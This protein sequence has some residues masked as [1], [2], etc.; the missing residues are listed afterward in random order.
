MMNKYSLQRLLP[1]LMALGLST[2]AMAQVTLQNSSYTQDFDGIGTAL[3]VGFSVR[4]G[5]TAT[6]LGTEVALTTAKTPWA[7]TSGRFSNYASADGLTA[8]ADAA[9]QDASTDRALG[10]RQTGSFGDPGAAFVFQAVNTTNKTSFSLSFKLQS[11]DNTSARTTAWR[12]DYG[13]GENPTNFQTIGSGTSLGNTSFSNTPITVD[14]ENALNNKSE[15]VWIRIVALANS[16]GSGSRPTTAIDDFSLTWN[17]VSATDPAISVPTTPLTFASQLINTASASQNY[18]ISAVNLTGDVTVT[19]PASFTVSK[20]NTAFSSTITFTPAELAT[21]KPVYVRY[22]PTAIG[23]AS[24]NIT[25]TTP[26]GV[27]QTVAVSGTAFDPNNLLFSFDNCTGSPSEGWTQFSVTGAQTWGCTTFGRDANDA[28]GKASKPNGLQINGF[29]G[30]SVLN[31][32]WLISPALNTSSFAYPLLSFYSRVAFSGAPL[33]LK[34][35]TNYSGTGSPNAAGVTWT[36]V[37]AAFPAIGSDTWTLTDNVDL[38]AF[39]SA[40]L[41]VAFVYNS[42]TDE[43]ARWTLDDIRVR[44]STTA[45]P[46]S[47]AVN[48]ST[49]AFGYRAPN[50]VTTQTLNVT[51]RDLTAAAT[52]TSSN[53]VFQLSKDGTAFSNSISFDAIEASSTPK[54]I[55]VRFSPTQASTSYSSTLT[56]ASTGATS[57]TIDATGNTYNV[58]NTLEVVSWNIEWFGSQAGLGPQDKALQQE[59]V[60]TML[61]NLNADIFALAEVVDTVRLGTVVR[62]LGGYRYMV[63]PAASGGSSA[64]NN[65]FYATA[66]K[67]VFVYRTSVIK[68]PTFKVLLECDNQATNCAAYSDW[69]SGRYPYSM[70]ADV[71][72]N[73]TT[74]HM[75]V[76]LIHAKANTSP[77]VD[78]YNR[79]KAGA[80]ALKAKLDADYPTTKFVIVGDYND[81]LDETITAGAPTTE[82][83]YKAFVDDAANY[84]A[85]TLPL[86]L[87]K[88]KSTVS[89]NDVIDHAVA[90]NELAANYLTGSA[91]IQTSLA[92]LIPNYANTTSDHYPVQTRYVFGTVT[93]TKSARLAQQLSISPN[94]VHN[95]LSLQLPTQVG[96]LTLNVTSTDG[97]VVFV[98]TGRAELLTQQLSQRVG[99][100]KAGM[101]LVRAT[102]AQQ[103]YF[104]RFVKQ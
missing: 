51:L 44:N 63:S 73:G 87:A 68:N 11:L 66:Q 40:T 69:S 29:S 96:E 38:S 37:D 34:V 103:V 42:T 35:S 32:D 24:G 74:N 75:L 91:E 21:A 70:E 100:L 80:T 33:Q 102:S 26:G 30:S 31:E 57:L 4:T 54:T 76:V 104:G 23:A 56:V 12:V 36:T 59:N 83:S 101:Y 65:S 10:V 28:T 92:A 46:P 97:R 98:G 16:T 67:L 55:A 39:K 88:K 93:S 94:P 78:A 64:G 79:R 86:S 19:A 82:S 15:K 8:A 2:G 52:I 45:P 5:A 90:S 17:T 7:N 49:L 27:N 84:Q 6:A 20:D 77:V 60:K 62:Q 43:A 41:Y 53:P 48:T 18:Q 61:T 25:H 71:E 1:A 9:A 81:D 13:T 95:T 22:T 50:T 89:Y 58:A 3:P 72:L 85:L 47:L 14:F 99:S